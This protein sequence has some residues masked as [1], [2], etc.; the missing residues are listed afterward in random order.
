MCDRL[1]FVARAPV[2]RPRQNA[3][4]RTNQVFDLEANY[5]Q[6]VKTVLVVEDTEDLRELFIDVL[7]DA[8]YTA[9]GAENGRDAL[10]AIAAMPEKPCLVLLD[11]MMP[12]MDG[13]EF[14]NAI[15]A[16]PQ[17]AA[18][19]VVVVSAAT[20]KP[21]AGVRKVMKKPIAMDALLNVV[22][23]FCCQGS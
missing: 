23:E 17:L 7:A 5:T 2:P 13:A 9:R 19:P 10:D 1:R 4:P 20:T 14:L 3:S 12:V 8:G 22:S 15:H 18:L 16:N 6:R 11:M 21:P